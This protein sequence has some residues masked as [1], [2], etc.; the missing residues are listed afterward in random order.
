MGDGE[1]V[2]RREGPHVIPLAVRSTTPSTTSRFL[3]W[4]F[5]WLDTPDPASVHGILWQILTRLRA[6]E[7]QGVTI[8]ADVQELSNELDTIKTKVDAVLVTGQEQVALI[9]ALKDQIAAGTP[10]T[11]EQLDALDAKADSILASLTP[12]T[13]TPEAPEAPAV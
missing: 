2:E 5:G 8:M 10:V 4:L 13:P 9:Q 12:A 1:T 6:L 11:Q 3:Q 7:A